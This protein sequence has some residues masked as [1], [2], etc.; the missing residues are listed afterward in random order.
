M[1]QHLKLSGIQNRCDALR[2]DVIDLQY[3]ELKP[4][5][6]IKGSPIPMKTVRFALRVGTSTLYHVYT[7]HISS[8]SRGCF[9]LNALYVGL[10]L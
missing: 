3:P 4:V 10:Q 5:V 1:P 8:A 2:V 7:E 9:R 6:I